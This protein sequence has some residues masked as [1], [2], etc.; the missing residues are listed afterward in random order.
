MYC[1]EIVFNFDEYTF[2]QT[3]ILNFLEFYKIFG[4]HSY[5]PSH[6]Y[7]ST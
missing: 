2:N 6:A 1:N 3:V 5:T 7:C 4:L